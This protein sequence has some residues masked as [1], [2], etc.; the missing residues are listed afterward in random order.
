MTAN[1]PEH[2]AVDR[3]ARLAFT[4]F[5]RANRHE[6]LRFAWHYAAPHLDV[7]GIVAEAWAR[8]CAR[9]EVINNPRPW[10]YRVV[11]NLIYEAGKA[12]QR[13]QPSD[14]PYAAGDPY[15]R[16]ISAASLPGAE[17]AARISEITQALQRLPGQ[18]RAAVLLDY[19]G[20]TRAEIAAALGCTAVTVRG[21]LHRGRASLKVM[22]GE[23]EPAAQQA[24]SMGLEGRTT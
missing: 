19:R 17:W 22:L 4:N 12:A 5:Y 15:V 18:Q 13:T 16:W 3:A 14:N 2:V 1:G 9:W 20:W 24:R 23:I 11:I 21:H 10:L 6:L 8:A 7:E